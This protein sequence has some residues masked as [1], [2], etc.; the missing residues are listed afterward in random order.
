MYKAYPIAS[1]ESGIETVREPWLAMENSVTDMRNAHVW[2]GRITKR[3]GASLFGHIPTDVIDEPLGTPSVGATFI[4]NNDAGSLGIAIPYAPTGADKLAKLVN[5]PVLAPRT[6]P[7]GLPLTLGGFD[8][9]DDYTV[10]LLL[11]PYRY[12]LANTPYTQPAPY[13]E[14]VYPLIFDPTYSSPPGGSDFGA[15]NIVT[16][17]WAV[18]W[19]TTPGAFDGTACTATYTFL[20]QLPPTLITTWRR[21]TGE[22]QLVV[23]DTKRLFTYDATLQRLTD[24]L[25]T[26]YTLAT[27]DV[28]TSGINDFM[29]SATVDDGSA[30]LLVLCNG[31]NEPK[32]WDGSALTNMGVSGQFTSAR[33]VFGQYGHVVYL[34]VTQGGVANRQKA[35]WSDQ[36]LT[37]TVTPANY[38]VAYT[39][40]SII[41]ASMVNDEIVVFFSKSVW[42]LRYTGDFRTG[43]QFEWAHVS[44]GAFDRQ[45]SV[46]AIAPMGSVTVEDH[47]VAVSSHG[48][49]AANANGTSEML[50]RVP[51]LM[52]RFFNQT[53]MSTSYGVAW[54]E[55]HKLWFTACSPGGTAEPD[56][57]MTLDMK[58]EAVSF[59]YWPFRIF[60]LYKRQGMLEPNWDDVPW[61][62]TV[63]DLVVAPVDGAA[64]SLGYPIVLAG[65]LDGSIYQVPPA[66]DI[67]ELGDSTMTVEFK[68]MNPFTQDGV[69]ADLGLLVIY[70][71][72][73]NGKTARVS[74]YRDHEDVPH[75]VA[76]IDLTPAPGKTRIEK[77]I[78]VNKTADFHK[79]K[80]EQTGTSR[81]SIDA[82]MP[83]FQPAGEMQRVS[84]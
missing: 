23:C 70:A 22:E 32:K 26:T 29:S 30:R 14:N 17:E 56:T 15:V 55:E 66:I 60:G 78:R 25:A 59:Y 12:K 51:D 71:S 57:T 7:A 48:L 84:T 53:N 68:Q 10:T 54:D 31:V 38:A 8:A 43:A 58:N 35:M 49:M 33:F 65:R 67:D 28:W 82:L 6:S 1:F 63:F 5:L 69:Q 21:P 46:G 13:P 4:G 37:E 9:V 16:G 64:Q 39:S 62:D 3:P 52:V 45:D 77:A 83:Y 18:L 42:K 40:D 20:R 19:S 2:R 36:F 50:S 81:W 76:I 44:G 73:L 79:F 41:T 47:A 61:K 72:P 80:I 11:G 34:N 24:R 74:I 27:D 75:T